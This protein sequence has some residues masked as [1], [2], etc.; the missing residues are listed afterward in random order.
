MTRER[1]FFRG[2]SRRRWS[3]VIRVASAIV[4]I[5]GTIIIAVII[6]SIAIR[7]MIGRGR[8]GI[9]SSR[10]APIIALRIG[11]ASLHSFVEKIIDIIEK[12]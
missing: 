1:L 6:T 12:N 5:S 10:S 2:R 11:T 8:V 7:I 9:R 4:V 3:S